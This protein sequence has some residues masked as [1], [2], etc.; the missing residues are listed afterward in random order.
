MSSVCLQMLKP[1]KNTDAETLVNW[2]EN[3]VHEALERKYL[4]TMTFGVCSD[5]E[6]SASP[7]HLLG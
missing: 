4:A 6:Q 2:I 1:Q 7:V 5:P 3:G